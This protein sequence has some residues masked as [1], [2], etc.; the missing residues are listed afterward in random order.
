MGRPAADTNLHANHARDRATHPYQR[1][2]LVGDE[3]CPVAARIR[4]YRV[5]GARAAAPGG[6]RL[7]RAHHPLGRVRDRCGEQGSRKRGQPYGARAQYSHL[8]SGRP[9][10][11]VSA[12]ASFMARNSAAPISR[13][14]IET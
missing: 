3:K 7:A 12:P 5:A 10:R 9:C 14:F 4:P 6:N 13:F 8:S 2:R 11:K 1:K